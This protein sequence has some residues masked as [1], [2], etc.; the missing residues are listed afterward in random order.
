MSEPRTERTDARR[1]YRVSELLGGLNALL[2]ERVGRVWV[3]G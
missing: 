2:E 3:I 1:F